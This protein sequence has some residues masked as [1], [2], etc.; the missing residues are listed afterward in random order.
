MTMDIQSNAA[1]DF[2]SYQETGHG[3]WWLL[4]RSCDYSCMKPNHVH[5]A[6]LMRTNEQIDSHIQGSQMIGCPMQ[7][8]YVE[9]RHELLC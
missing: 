6:M 7:T 4:E 8:M 5:A 3:M 9:Y 2:T 1:L